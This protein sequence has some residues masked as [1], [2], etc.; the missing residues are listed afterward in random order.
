[1]KQKYRKETLIHMYNTL[2]SLYTSHLYDISH[3][4]AH[5]E[6]GVWFGSN[7]GFDEVSWE[8]QVLVNLGEF[9][10]HPD[11]HTLYRPID[12]NHRWF[13][14]DRFNYAS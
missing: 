13:F 3:R 5:D 11:R 12:P 10:R 4:W 2:I 6:E 8:V 14:E 7:I 9:V 1:M